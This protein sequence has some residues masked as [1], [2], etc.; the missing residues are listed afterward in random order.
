M[1][2]KA[3]TPSYE[4]T[5]IGVMEPR[6]R[7]AGIIV[8]R[9]VVGICSALLLFFL[10]PLNELVQRGLVALHNWAGPAGDRLAGHRTDGKPAVVRH[11]ASITDQWPV[12]ITCGVMVAVAVALLGRKTLDS[13]RQSK[14]A[15]IAL[16]TVV[17]AVVVALLWWGGTKIPQGRAVWAVVLH[18]TSHAAGAL[19][20]FVAGVEY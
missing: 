6:T 9:F 1:R 15:R 18:A 3:V 16:V 2:S 7:K 5:G 13:P 11:I 12:V 4:P 8:F 19:A 14:V 20:E 10:R 17:A